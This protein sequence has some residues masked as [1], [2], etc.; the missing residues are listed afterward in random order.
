MSI[1]REE[2]T[3]MTNSRRSPSTSL[4]RAGGGLALAGIGLKWIAC[5]LQNAWMWLGG[6]LVVVA[7]IAGAFVWW[8]S[9]NS[10]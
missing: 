7:I 2:S 6:G 3:T 9:R 5:V 10:W 1:L 8:R 4:L